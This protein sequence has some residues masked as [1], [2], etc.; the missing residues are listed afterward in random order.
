MWIIANAK[1]GVSSCEIHR[2]IGVTQKTAWFMLHRIRLAMQQGSIEKLSGQVEADETYIGG[3]A[4]NMHK[5]KRGQKI[6]GRGSSGKVA[7]MGLLERHGKV[8][9]KVIPDTRSRTLHVEIR[10]NIAPGSE[11]HTDALRSYRGL[12]PEYSTM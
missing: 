8:K 11:I 2:A 1:N 7:V 4:R 10:E 3:K 9:T 5:S 12:D 6:T